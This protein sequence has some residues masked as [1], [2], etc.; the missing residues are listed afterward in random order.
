MKKLWKQICRI[1]VFASAVMLAVEAFAATKPEPIV[2]FPAGASEPVPVAVWLHGLR[3]SRACW[4]TRIT[5]SGL[6]MS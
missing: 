1:P 5:F 6:R 4:K 3:A 2:Y